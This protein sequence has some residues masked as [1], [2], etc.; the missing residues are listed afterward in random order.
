MKTP[1]F[2]VLSVL[3]C[4]FFFAVPAFAATY[5]FS[6]LGMASGGFKPQGNRFL[7]SDKFTQNSTSM[8]YN[9]A[10]ASETGMVIKPNGTNLASFDLGNLSVSSPVGARTVSIT[11]T[12]DL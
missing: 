11:I 4:V 6:N 7:V 9:S 2:R 3:F 1:L 10:N 12:A 8:Y 5:D